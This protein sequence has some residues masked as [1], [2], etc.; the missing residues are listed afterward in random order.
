M[1]SLAKRSPAA[2]APEDPAIAG[3]KEKVASLEATVEAL[4]SRLAAL[5]EKAA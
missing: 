2:P 3:L 4:S 1:A 5:E